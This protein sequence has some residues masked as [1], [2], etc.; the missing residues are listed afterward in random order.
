[1]LIS[2]YRFGRIVVH[3]TKPPSS[4]PLP[5]PSF[6]FLQWYAFSLLYNH[7]LNTPLSKDFNKWQVEKALPPSLFFKVCFWFIFLSSFCF[8]ASPIME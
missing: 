1:M 3:L 4:L 8:L 6:Y 5:P 7:R 2:P